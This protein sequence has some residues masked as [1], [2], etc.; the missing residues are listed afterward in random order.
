VNY[1]K[2]FNDLFI[3]NLLL[4]VMVKEFWRS[5]R[6]R[7][8]WEKNKWHLIFRTRCIYAIWYLGHLWPFGKILRRSSQGNTPSGELNTRG[9]A[10]YS[11]FGRIER[12]ISETV[13]DI[14]SPGE[15]IGVFFIIS[16]PR[17]TISW[18]RDSI[19]F[20]RDT[21]SRERDTI[22]FPQDS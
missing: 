21:N 11:D 19:S 18:E 13:R 15:D 14:R 8:L 16:L 12:Y 10:E 3:A 17:V 9:V 7:Q 22:S 6:I 5:V 20:P 4:S 1:G 2:I